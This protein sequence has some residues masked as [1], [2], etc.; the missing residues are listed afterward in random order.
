MGKII[1]NSI[2]FCVRK[3]GFKNV[4][5]L[6]AAKEGNNK[7]MNTT[8]V[9]S[10]PIEGKSHVSVLWSGMCQRGLEIP[11]G[12]GQPTARKVNRTYLRK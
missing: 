2:G 8:H 7:I 3:D 5:P 11:T 9:M 1:F 6:K 10:K 4:L 12:I